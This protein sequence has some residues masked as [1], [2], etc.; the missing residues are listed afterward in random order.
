MVFVSAIEIIVRWISPSS[1]PERLAGSHVILHLWAMM[2]LF[3]VWSAPFPLMLGLAMLVSGY[4][5]VPNLMDFDKYRARLLRTLLAGVTAVISLF[6]IY[7]LLKEISPTYATGIESKFIQTLP[8]LNTCI[9]HKS[10]LGLAIRPDSAMEEISRQTDLERDLVITSSRLPMD[11]RHEDPDSG[12]T[13]ARTGTLSANE[14]PDDLYFYYKGS[15]NK[16]GTPPPPAG[17]Q[18]V[19][20]ADN[21]EKLLDIVIGSGTIYPLFP[22]RTIHSIKVDNRTVPAIDIIDGGFIHNVPVDAAVKWGATHIILIEASAADKP[23][24]PHHFLDNVLVAFNYLFAQAQH[25]DS[26]KGSTEIFE[27]R[28]SSECEKLSKLH[29]CDETTLPDMDTFDFDR[30]ILTKAY[31]MGDSDMSSPS[32]PLKRRSG[33]PLFRDAVWSAERPRKSD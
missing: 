6:L 8:Q 29:K 9:G 13:A 30:R 27:L 7:S 21:K 5:R 14:L 11:A 3:S 1:L 24:A 22:F 19:S 4:R 16:N 23:F 32:A 15:S 12:T 10:E 17:T 18:F 31:E 33:E 26:D 20:L 28:P 2:K 25:I